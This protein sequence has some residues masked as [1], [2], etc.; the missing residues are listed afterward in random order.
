M[1]ADAF[2]FTNWTTNLPTALSDALNQE[3]SAGVLLFSANGL[4]INTV[5]NTFAPIAAPV[6]SLFTASN[7]IVANISLTAVSLYTDGPVVVQG[8]VGTWFASG[9]VTVQ[10]TNQAAAFNAKLWD[11]TTVISA[12]DINTPGANFGSMSLSGV[13]T[14]PV[15]NIRISV[16]D[17]S[18]TGGLI[19]ANRTGTSKDS[20][21]TA[22]RIA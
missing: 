13:I 19:I 12:T 7:S 6:V 2:K 22:V 15:G 9:T 8:S 16:Q 10:D 1:V 17:L 5:T 4:V 14:N 20:T 3:F 21:I 11:G 18:T